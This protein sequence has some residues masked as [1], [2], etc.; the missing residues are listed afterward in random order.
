MVADHAYTWTIR[1]GDLDAKKEML[2]DG[3]A[4]LYEALVKAQTKWLNIR[5][6]SPLFKGNENGVYPSC[7]GGLEVDSRTTERNKE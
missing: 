1:V 7:F 3:E 2:Y 4:N 6:K 5:D